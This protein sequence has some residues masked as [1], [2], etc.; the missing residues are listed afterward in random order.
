MM[1]LPSS[2]VGTRPFGL[3]ARYSGSR[4]RPNCKPASTRSNGML[5]SA[6][7]HSTFWTFDDVI[8]PQILSMACLLKERS[9]AR[10]S[11][12]NCPCRGA[13]T[14]ELGAP[15]NVHDLEDAR[16]RFDRGAHARADPEA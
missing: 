10:L 15:L 7:A 6:H 2:T 1:V 5:S 12:A 16:E 9:P 14:S 3:I 4:T 13:A 11:D 8:R